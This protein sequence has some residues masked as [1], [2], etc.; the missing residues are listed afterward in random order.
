MMSRLFLTLMLLLFLFHAKAQ[1]FLSLTG[2]VKPDYRLISDSQVNFLNEFYRNKVDISNDLINGREY[3]PYYLKCRISP[4]LFEDRKH[5]GSLMFNGSRYFNLQLEYDTYLD[6]L[7]YSDNSKL[8]DSKTFKIALNKDLVEAF[9]LYFEGDSLIFRHFRKD[10]TDSLNLPEGY[11]EVVYDG[12]SKYIIRHQSA[13]VEED[14]I[15]EYR[16]I[17]S[18]YILVGKSFS[19]LRSS[20]SFKESFGKYSDAI[21]KYMR[22]NRIDFRHAGKSD[23]AAVLRYYDS[24]AMSK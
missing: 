4:I 15:Y 9:G 12:K 19:K 1:E 21:R 18:V 17:P 16:Q 23:V 10:A 5:S 7:I 14:G 24:M 3:V 8:I 22:A 6:Q 2:D 13:L 11:Y 20:H